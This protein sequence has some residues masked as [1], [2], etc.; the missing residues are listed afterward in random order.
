MSSMALCPGVDD[1]TAPVT[2]DSPM[3]AV[4]RSIAP[5]ASLYL[6]VSCGLAFMMGPPGLGDVIGRKSTVA[7]ASL[8][9]P[10]AWVATVGVG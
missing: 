1:A 5:A 2:G 3:G 6:L 4:V 10:F 7:G 9:D 8:T